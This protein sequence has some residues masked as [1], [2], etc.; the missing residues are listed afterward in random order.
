MKVGDL[1]R[2][3]PHPDDSDQETQMA[4]Y[5]GEVQLQNTWLK[6]STVTGLREKFL[7]KKLAAKFVEVV[8]ES[9]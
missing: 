5:L 6:F 2:I 8:N 4:I 9:R 1:V 3:L 7:S